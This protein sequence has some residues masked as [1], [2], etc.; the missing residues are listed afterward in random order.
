MF[1]VPRSIRFDHNHPKASE[2]RRIFQSIAGV[3]ELN[4][5][6]ILQSLACE[7]MFN[8]ARD[9]QRRHQKADFTRAVNVCSSCVRSGWTRSPF[10][11]IKLQNSDWLDDDSLAALRSN[12]LNPQRQTDKELGISLQSLVSDRTCGRLTKPHIFCERLRLFRALR[13]SFDAEPCS[14]QDLAKRVD[15]AWPATLLGNR[16]CMWNPAQNEW[17]LILKSTAYCARCMSVTQLPRQDRRMIFILDDQSQIYDS[18]DVRLEGQGFSAV[19]PVVLE[20]FF[21]GVW[22][23]L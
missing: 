14:E 7:L 13:A 2:V 10:E 15:D 19:H 8:D 18:I 21:F 17:V 3:T 16:V 9:C 6:P 1:L 4:E 5:E 12:V 20:A 11:S 23:D 22:V